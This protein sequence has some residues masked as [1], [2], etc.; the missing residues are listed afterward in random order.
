MTRKRVRLNCQTTAQVGEAIE[1]LL[2]TGLYGSS[3]AAVVER[4][5][6]EALQEKARAGLIK[7]ED[8]REAVR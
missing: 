1:Q 4:L 5:V 2:W 8:L 3:R 7:V 6:C